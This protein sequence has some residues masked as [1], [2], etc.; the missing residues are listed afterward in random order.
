MR[1]HAGTPSESRSSTASYDARLPPY[2]DD[3]AARARRPPERQPGLDDD[4]A[5]D[6]GGS[7]HPRMTVRVT[8]DVTS[9]G[10]NG[11][12]LADDLGR[13]R[14]LRLAGGDVRHRTQLD[15]PRRRRKRRVALDAASARR[16]ASA[17][18]ARSAHA[19]RPAEP[20]PRPA[21]PGR[22]PRGAAPRGRRATSAAR[23][24][25]T[26]SSP[27][28]WPTHSA[29]TPASSARTADSS[30]PT[31]ALT[32]FISS[33]S[34]STSPSKPSSSRSSPCDD[35][36]AERRGR[37]VERGD[38]HVR[39]HDRLHA[40]GDRGPERLEPVFDVAGDASA[41]RDASPA[42]SRRGPESASRRRRR[43]ATACP[44]T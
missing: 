40:G 23:M 19:A 9:A 27:R 6:V 36:R 16:A 28:S 7:L 11:L 41:A 14:V 1:A 5:V 44:R 21:Q 4:G 15:D 43:G 32:A 24:R 33:A 10:G 31:V 22:Q 26:S 13:E 8:H 12:A 35:A 25:T 39:G 42:R 37:V 30:T 38:A 3:V 18:P 2:V 20:R 17:A 34:A 29:S